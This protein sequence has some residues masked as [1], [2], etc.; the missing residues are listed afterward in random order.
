MA[1]G[2]IIVGLK[3]AEI[4]SAAK[5]ILNIPKVLDGLK[6]KKYLDEPRFQVAVAQIRASLK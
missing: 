5:E 2:T 3:R 6:V 1:L 4:T